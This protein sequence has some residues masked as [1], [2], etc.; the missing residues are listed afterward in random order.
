MPAQKKNPNLRAVLAV[1]LPPAVGRLLTRAAAKRHKSVSAFLRD[2]AVEEANR[3]LGV[4]PTETEQ[5]TEP[6]ALSA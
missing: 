2:A 1:S 6:A 4:E 3:I 5:P